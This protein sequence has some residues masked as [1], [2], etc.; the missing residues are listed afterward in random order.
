MKS[1]QALERYNYLLGKCH[2]NNLSIEM[3]LMRTVQKMHIWSMGNLDTLPPEYLSVL[4]DLLC[5]MS[6]GSASNTIW[7]NI[8]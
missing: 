7:T 8:M 6:G 2:T 4:K 5:D 3:Q 1:K